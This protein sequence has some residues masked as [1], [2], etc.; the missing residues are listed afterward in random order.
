MG[1]VSH[2]YPGAAATTQLST[3]TEC[4]VFQVVHVRDTIISCL[5]TVADE[6]QEIKL[7]N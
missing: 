2:C 1:L 5:L 6:R 7:L 3:V 4:T